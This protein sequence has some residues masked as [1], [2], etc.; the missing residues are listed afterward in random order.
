MIAANAEKERC[1]EIY[2]YATE[3]K[4]LAR[5]GGLVLQGNKDVPLVQCYNSSN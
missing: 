1:H 4:E 2:F 3:P 5:A